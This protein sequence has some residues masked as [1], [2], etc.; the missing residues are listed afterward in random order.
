[1][2]SKRSESKRGAN[3]PAAK[4]TPDQVAAIRRYAKRGPHKWGW[5]S[6]LAR[7]YGV[8]PGTVSDILAGRIWALPTNVG[9]PE[10]NGKND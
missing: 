5:R 2:T 1:M 7:E 4:L 6:K 8:S 10:K 9:T 3:N